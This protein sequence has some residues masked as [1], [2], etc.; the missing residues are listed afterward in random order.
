MDINQLVDELTF[1]LDRAESTDWVAFSIKADDEAE[2]LLLDLIRLQDRTEWHL[3][4]DYYRT[5]T[6]KPNEKE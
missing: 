6:E 5:D 3:A 4:Q 2:E 1:G